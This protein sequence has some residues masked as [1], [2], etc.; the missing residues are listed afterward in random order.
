MKNVKYIVLSGIRTSSQGVVK[1]CY[2]GQ[3]TTGV[4]VCNGVYVKDLVLG[5]KSA[6]SVLVKSTVCNNGKFVIKNRYFDPKSIEI[7]IYS[8]EAGA[9]IMYGSAGKTRAWGGN[10]S[11]GFNEREFDERENTEDEK[12]L[13]ENDINAEIKQP[14]PRIRKD[15]EFETPVNEGGSNSK[16]AYTGIIYSYISENLEKLFDT[17]EHEK[18]LEDIISDSVWIRIFIDETTYYVVGKIYD[19]ETV[20][21]GFGSRGN[22]NGK[23][24]D[25]E[26]YQF[27]PI[28][29]FGTDE[30]YWIAVNS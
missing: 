17:S 14:D 4:F 16:N 23:P 7:V 25:E 21:V 8:A 10:I 5:I 19:G 30:G 28:P 11:D 9:P 15:I 27:V 2:D 24:M 26:V 6:S 22:K 13:D 18:A 1:V 3:D 29:E 20:C 12:K